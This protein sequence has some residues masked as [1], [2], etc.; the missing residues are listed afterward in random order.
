MNWLFVAVANTPKA[1]F[2]PDPPDTDPEDD[3]AA[4]LL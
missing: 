1:L 4:L 3:A 2:E